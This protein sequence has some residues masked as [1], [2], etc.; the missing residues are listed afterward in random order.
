MQTIPQQSKTIVDR[1]VDKLIKALE[2]GHSEILKAY[3]SAMGRFHRFSWNN[4]FLI[5]CQCPQA[6]HVAGFKTW[7]TLGR[8]VKKGSKGIMIF[9]P[10]F[11]KKSVDHRNDKE[12][13]DDMV[14]AFR[15][16]YVFDVSQTEGKPLPDLCQ[17]CGDAGVYLGRLHDFVKQSGIAIEY[18]PMPNAVEGMSCGGV[19][20][21]KENMSSAQ[22]MSVL[23]H[24]WAHERLHRDNVAAATDKK[25]R[26]TEAEAVA[27]IVCEAVGLDTSTASTDYIQLYRGDKDTLV[28]SLDRIQKTAG[29]IIHAITDA[30]DMKNN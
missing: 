21:L 11:C 3:L 5:Q 22:E 28:A 9:A 2:S 23:A 24:E 16:V 18:C 8:R 27:F 13:T 19:I 20:K 15:A 7:Q 30:A 14:R 6:T 25:V 17:T 10:I 4:A 1:A 26:E 29:Q 12:E